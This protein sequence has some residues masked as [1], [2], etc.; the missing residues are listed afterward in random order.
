MSIQQQFKRIDN[1]LLEDAGTSGA[2]DYITQISWILF[3]KYLD[4]LE[5]TRREEAVFKSGQYEPTFKEEFS[6]DVWAC[7]KLP[8]GKPDL[9]RQLVGDDLMKFVNTKLFPYLKSF[10]STTEDPRSVHYKIGVIYS[11]IE[12]KI[13]SGRNLREILDLID[14]LEFKT[15]EELDDLSALYEDRLKLL[16]GAGRSGEFYTPRPL[17]QAM[18]L[19][20]DPK[21]GKTIYDGAAGSAGFLTESYVYLRDKAKTP[22]ELRF[23]K[24]DTF[25]GKNKKPEPYLIGTMNMILHGMES[26]NMVEGNTLAEDTHDIQD[27]DRFDYIL[28]NPPFG[29]SEHAEVQRNFTIKSSETAELFMQH[30]MKKLRIGG[31]SAIVIKNTFLTNGNTEKTSTAQIRKEL[32]SNFNLHT[33]L[34]LPSGIFSANS[35]TGVKTVVLFFKKGEPTR[36]IF[37]YQLNLGRTLGKTTPLNIDDMSDFLEKYESRVDSENSW[38]VNI[39]EVNKK[40]FDLRVNNPNVTKAEELKSPR[41]ILNKIKKI[42]N[43][44]A[45]VLGEIDA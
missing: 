6:W 12:Q 15:Q 11:E 36:D 4:D 20:I 3:L 27:K 25:F 17:I 14:P 26:P 5:D 22:S 32:L 30:F 45:K 42:D 41:E 35:S 16:G 23:L 21:L 44:I 28:A 10:K 34:D 7:P 43:E 8:N 38:T 18:I 13:K 40:T 1:I 2:N 39:T 29:G 37:Y 19:A 33:V 24:E 31:E 9:S